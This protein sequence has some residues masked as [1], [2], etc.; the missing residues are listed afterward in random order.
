VGLSGSPRSVRLGFGAQPR[1]KRSRRRRAG[2]R[3]AAGGDRG[4]LAPGR[5]PAM[6]SLFPR[7]WDQALR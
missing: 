3:A 6:R 5:G 7:C 4:V 2:G 1:L